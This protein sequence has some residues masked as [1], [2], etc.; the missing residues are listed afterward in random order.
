MILKA[1]EV[2]LTIHLQLELQ[3]VNS[4]IKETCSNLEKQQKNTKQ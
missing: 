1:E 3:H 2:F 4:E